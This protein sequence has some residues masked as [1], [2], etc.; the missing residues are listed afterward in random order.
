MKYLHAF[1]EIYLKFVKSDIAYQLLFPS[2][3]G[4]PLFWLFFRFLAFA[5]Q[6]EQE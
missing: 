5:T 2:H 1:I 3:F 4:L 6:I